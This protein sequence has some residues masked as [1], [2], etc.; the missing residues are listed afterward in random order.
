MPDGKQHKLVWKKY[1][2]LPMMVAVIFFVTGSYY[3]SIW[4]IFGYLLHGFG[5]ITNDLDLISIDSGEAKWIKSVILIPLVMWSTLYSR[6]IQVLGGHRSFWSHGFVI[7]SFIRLMWFGFP[8]IAIFRYFFAD[9]L[10]LEFFGMLIGLSIADSIHSLLDITSGEISFL[11]LSKKGSK[12]G[13][14]R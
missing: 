7:S 5:G 2:L 13:R 14:K 12:H 6:I 11:R 10:Y 4:I 8:F 3:F 1:F 9:P